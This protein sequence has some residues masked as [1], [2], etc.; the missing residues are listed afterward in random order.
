MFHSWKQ[1]K[2]TALPGT[3]SETWQGV[4]KQRLNADGHTPQSLEAT[5]ENEKSGKTRSFDTKKSKRSC[6]EQSMVPRDAQ[7][8]SAAG[9]A[10]LATKGSSRRQSSLI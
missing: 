1:N 4:A 3:G 2:Q 5:L 7:W 9:K 6:R 10:K 8:F